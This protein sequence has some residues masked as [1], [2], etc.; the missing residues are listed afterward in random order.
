MKCNGG[1]HMSAKRVAIIV[2]VVMFVIGCGFIIKSL[3]LGYIYQSDISK[4][5]MGYTTYFYMQQGYDEEEAKSKAKE[6]LMEREELYQK[7]VDAG[8][9]V[10][11]EEVEEYLDSLKELI[12]S[13]EDGEEQLAISMNYF[14][15]EDE[16]WDYEF[17]VYQKNLV[18]QKY[19]K[20]MDN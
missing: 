16:Y 7:A 14:E 1:L 12:Y 10:T 18:I 11:D 20:D 13:S 15:N 19:N 17:L 4:E 6:Y 5:E 8:Y 2:A 9:S 3:I